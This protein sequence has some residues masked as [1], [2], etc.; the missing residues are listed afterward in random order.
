[1]ESLKRGIF[2]IALPRNN[3]NNFIFGKQGTFCQILQGAV[4]NYLTMISI[5]YSLVR[6][7]VV[8]LFPYTSRLEVLACNLNT[9]LNYVTTMLELDPFLNH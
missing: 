3:L 4:P 5:D 6:I 2:G 8:Q 7:P 1:M 9:N